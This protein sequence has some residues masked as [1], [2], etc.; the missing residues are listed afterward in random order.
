MFV[1]PVLVSRLVRLGR[2][3][4]L[5][6]GQ[7][8]LPLL[9]HFGRTAMDV[10]PGQCIPESIPVGERAPCAGTRRE[11]AQPPLETQDLSQP[12]DVAARQR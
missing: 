3:D 4:G 10:E 6:V 9:D 11:V 5:A 1:T 12:L 8:C 2:F 7:Q